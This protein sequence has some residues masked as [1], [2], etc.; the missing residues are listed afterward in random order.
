VPGRLGPVQRTWMALAH[1]ISRVTTPIVIG[2][3]FFGV[4]TPA[5]LIANALGHHPLVRKGATV[6]VPRPPDA[7]KSDLNRQF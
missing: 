7:R 1:A 2:V 5:G 3:I 4:L 6:W